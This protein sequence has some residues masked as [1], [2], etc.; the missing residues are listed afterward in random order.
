MSDGQQDQTL[1]ELLESD[2]YA[3]ESDIRQSYR[4]LIEE[5]FSIQDEEEKEA[6]F[7]QLHNAWKVLCDEERRAMY[8]ASL[9]KDS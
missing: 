7:H 9:D 2:R 8:D 3:H 4:R 6:R 5:S 1:Y